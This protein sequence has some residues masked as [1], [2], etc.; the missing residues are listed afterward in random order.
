MA[1]SA[2]FID[3]IQMHVRNHSTLSHALVPSSAVSHS[4]APEQK[5]L[6]FD[7]KTAGPES[8]GSSCPELDGSP[9][10]MYYA[11]LLAQETAQASTGA[12]LLNLR[13]LIFRTLFTRTST[14]LLEH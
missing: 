12:R 10:Q 4:S 3:P 5:E 1:F 6:V 13:G 14:V 8:S 11:S 9:G 7:R 2:S